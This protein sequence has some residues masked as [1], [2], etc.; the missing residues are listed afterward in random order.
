MFF[1]VCK[2]AFATIT[3]QCN[4]LEAMRHIYVALDMVVLSLLLLPCD[5][6]A[7]LF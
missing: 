4:Y 5:V 6:L 3:S 2:K 7:S 1:D